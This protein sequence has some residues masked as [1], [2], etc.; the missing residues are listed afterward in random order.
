MYEPVLSIDFGASYTKIAHRTACKPAP[1]RPYD[2]RAK[3]IIL[4]QS[5]LIPS[6]AIHT[7]KTRSPWLFGR[8]AAE[9]TPD[10]QMEVFQNWKAGLFLSQN[11]KDS[12]A[13]V[14]VAGQFFRWLKDKLE[15]AGVD[16]EKAHTRV[17]MPA[18]KTFDEK[19]LLIARCME[20][21]GW[22]SPRILKATEPHAN[23]LG[24]F[25][26]GRN[27]ATQAP[28]G[29]ILLNYGKMFGMGSTYVRHARGS[30][31][32]THGHLLTVA[33]VDIGAF[34]TDIASIT[35]DFHGDDMGDGLRYLRQ[36]SHVLGVI[37]DL[38]RPVFSA[39]KSLHGIN[40]SEV[41][42]K[43]TEI[44][45]QSLYHGKPY[46]LLVK[47]RGTINLG[48]EKDQEAVK[49]QAVRF[50]ERLW[51]TV[52]DFVKPQKPTK[53]YLTGGGGLIPALAEPL[54]KHLSTKGIIVAPLTYSGDTE[55]DLQRVATA[56]GGASLILQAPGL[57]NEPEDGLP[58]RLPKIPD[59]LPESYATCTCQGG[60]KDCCY[61]GGR[62][63]YPK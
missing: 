54:A 2:S 3:P 22:D 9:L 63:F 62:G 26:E 32:G 16:V 31:F 4:D 21:A 45:K 51:E 24:L 46:S 61:C 44:V 37:N 60:N 8:Q 43:E 42:F 13:A 18:F 48:D 52:S 41:S 20:L 53:V 58:R 30:I 35:F 17:A 14:I 55:Q 27:F 29:E 5:L 59:P 12:A 1:R 6:L 28:Q 23:V 11:N 40:W 33:V 10:S 38:D 25:S 49:T 36:E 7:K 47:G 39:L 56:L 50:A 57:R 15:A 19:A 34:T